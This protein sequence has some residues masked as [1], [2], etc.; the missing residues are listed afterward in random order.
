MA[1]QREADIMTFGMMVGAEFPHARTVYVWELLTLARRHGRLA[2]RACN[3][4][5]PGLEAKTEKLEKAIA[6]VCRKIDPGCVPVFSGDPRGATVK[7]R[8][9]SGRT[10]DFGGTGIVVPQ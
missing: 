5:V 1:T 7:L 8:V 10:N 2:E 3:E 4:D 9:P 6:D